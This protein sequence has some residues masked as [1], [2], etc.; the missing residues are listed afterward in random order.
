MDTPGMLTEVRATDAAPAESFL[1]LQSPHDQ[2][3]RWRP[4]E[5][6]ET[7]FEEQ[8]DALARE[9]RAGQL[10]VDTGNRTLTYAQLD[11]MAN[12]LARFLLADGAKAGDRIALLFDQGI[13]S[14]AAMLAVLKIRAAYVPLD[15]GFPADRIG[16]IMEDSGCS[17]VLT[18]NHLVNVLPETS[19][20]ALALDTEVPLIK[21]LPSSRLGE[22]EK[23]E[24]VEDL[25]YII[26][27]SGSTGRPK[28]VAIEHPSICNFL[29]VAAEVYGYRSDDRVYQ[30]LTIAFDFSVEE[31]WVPWMVGATLVPKPSS[32]S[33]LGADL[34]EY[35]LEN[36]ITAMCCVPTLLATIE[37]ELPDLRFL[38]VSGEACPRDLAERWHLPGRRFLNVYGP[39]EATVTATME[40]L[41]PGKPITL[42]QPLPTYTTMIL[43]PD[44]PRALAPGEM[45]ELGIA[46]IGVAAGYLNNPEKTSQV[47]IDDFLDIPNNPSGR[48]YRSGDLCRVNEF[49][50]IEYFGRIDTQVKIR[51]YRI[52]LSEIESVLLQVPG[53]AQAVV[54]THEPAP[55]MVELAAFYTLRSDV[56]SL[57][58]HLIQDELR[59]RL[60]GYMVPAYYEQLETMPMLPSDKADRKSL[61]TPKNRLGVA[62]DVEYVAPANGTE[63]ALAEQLGSVLGLELVSVEAHVFE[64]LGANSLTIA[65]FSAALRRETELPPL[66]V[67]DIYQHPTIRQLA[68]ALA[69]GTSAV[70]WAEPYD[71]PAAR[72]ATTFDFVLCG[73]LQAVVSLAYSGAL[74]FVLVAGYEWVIEGNGILELWLRSVGFTV[75]FFL[76]VCLAP[77][78]L[79][80]MVIGRWKEQHI[81]IWSL[82]YLRFWF[83]KALVQMNPMAVFVGTPVLPFYL[84]LMGAKIGSNV[85]IM[86]WSLPVCTDLLTIGDNTVIHKESHYLGY[87]A[88]QGWIQTGRV[89]LGENVHVSEKT[90]L[91]IH[92]TM[93]DGAQLGHASSLQRLQT[94]PAG[95]SWY[96]SP[97]IPADVRF[98]RVGPM[99]TS[100]RRRFVYGLSTLITNA[101]VFSPL[102]LLLIAL[103]LPPYLDTGH[104]N[105]AN[106]GFYLDLVLVS[107]IV[108]IGGLLLA[109]LVATTIPRLLYLLITPGKAYPLYGLHYAAHRAIF[110]LT[111]VFPLMHITA[112]SS[113]VVHYLRLLGYKQ[114]NLQ[115]TGSNFGPEATHENPYLTIVGS[116]TM[117]SDGLSVMN[118]EYSGTSFRVMPVTI[119]AKNFFGNDV[120]FPAAARTGDNVLFGSKTHVPTHGEVRED[121]GLLGS[122]PFE[123]P[124]TVDWGDDALRIDTPEGIQ[125]GLRAKNR[126]NAA[127]ITLYLLSRCVLAYVG[128]LAA[129]VVVAF[130]PAI[131]GLGL[132]VGIVGFYA[133]FAIFV[134]L[135][136]R[137]TYGFRRMVP[138]KSSIYDVPFW[139]HERFWRFIT[140]PLPAFNGT[141]FKPF[142]WRLLG[143][144]MGKR[145]FDDGCVIPEKTLVTI[146][147]DVTLNAHSIVQC[148]SMEDG[149]FKLDAIEIGDNATVGVYVY[150][151][152][153]V[154]MGEGSVVEPDSFLMKGARVPAGARFGGNPAQE[155]ET[156]PAVPAVDGPRV[157]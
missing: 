71:A 137:A 95:E 83:V 97:A 133:F 15:A 127:S 49:G 69:T 24:P 111:D 128:L 120:P 29:R 139:R 75:G 45:G 13:W 33:M 50:E 6:M 85:T 81:R 90:V 92:T 99:P 73:V 54:D 147:D 25:A 148:H 31:M 11:A 44:E 62:T 39:T 114:P 123:I 19:V 1:L 125:R 107:V 2:E 157:P 143:V 101:A 129:V 106:P 70:E 60:P 144:R 122:P 86:S 149:L 66:G 113:L 100:K 61:P 72:R 41:E 68:A 154:V 130:Y 12:Q 78:A 43:D 40:V 94:V 84:R 150:V 146:G 10:A 48:I 79:K 77:I 112:D 58:P 105:L 93:E 132:L 138:T 82:A 67:Q 27:T 35:L 28:G 156:A 118:A 80:W 124:R 20:I 56:S 21:Q 119:G 5:R 4:G 87:R 74:M 151:H 23:P 155:I 26:Y 126:H 116:G 98:Q 110:F 88:H 7:L 153:D 103:L 102:P 109:L 65:Q 121:V 152:Y 22:D 115:Q 63:E 37:G 51:G 9:G 14:Y 52:E 8:C 57:D 46:G 64:E 96:G 17:R 131:T 89:T 141:P 30:G 53:I 3:V 104:L 16:Y 145:V 76:L 59:D 18:L 108:V 34:E 42:G 91:D 134:I 117:V 55:G 140:Y 135:C 36:R 38:L 32:A 136:E 47:F 142:F